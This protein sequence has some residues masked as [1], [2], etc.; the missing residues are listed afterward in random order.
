MVIV[1]KRIDKTHNTRLLSIRFQSVI[2]GVHWNLQPS[3]RRIISLQKTHFISPILLVHFEPLK[4]KQP[5]YK[6]QS[7]W[8]QRVA[9]PKV[10]MYKYS[11]IHMQ[12]TI[13]C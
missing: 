9:G 10:P 12:V 6:G 13:P 1:V 2:T 7:S 4:S 11:T 3:E 5:L 8:S